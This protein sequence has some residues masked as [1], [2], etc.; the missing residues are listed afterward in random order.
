MAS[1]KSNLKRLIIDIMG[2]LESELQEDLKLGESFQ[3]G[4]DECEELSDL[5]EEEFE[6][7]IGVAPENTVQELIGM[8][9][10]AQR[11]LGSPY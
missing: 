6:I 11:R 3:M 7:R 8:I 5:V 2:P 10:K 9:Q 4:H 1:I